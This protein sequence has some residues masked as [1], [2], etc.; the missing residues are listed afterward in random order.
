MTPEGLGLNEPGRVLTG[1]S[2]PLRSVI[3][4]LRCDF[5]VWESGR[6]G[7]Y[8]KTLIRWALVTPEVHDR[9]VQGGGRGGGG[10]VTFTAKSMTL[11]TAHLTDKKTNACRE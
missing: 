4:A 9:R 10:P 11:L 1:T 3:S 5:D 7:R 8:Q 2:E 6:H